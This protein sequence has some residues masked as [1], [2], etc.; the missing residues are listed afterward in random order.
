MKRSPLPAR[1]KP[2]ARVRLKRPRVAIQRAPSSTVSDCQVLTTR[3]SGK[4]RKSTARGKKSL[5][6]RFGGVPQNPKYL[7]FVRCFPCILKNLPIYGAFFDTVVGAHVC[8]GKIESAHTGRH[9]GGQKAA[10]ETALPMCTNA[11]RTG[12]FAHHRLG[13]KF[14]EFWGL[15]QSKLIQSFNEM[16]RESEVLV[17]EFRS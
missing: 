8:S 9:G 10:D 17:Q 15:D 13:K 11:H 5:P 12:K 16:A 2:V 3:E 7:A 14:W 4:S 1:T 6:L